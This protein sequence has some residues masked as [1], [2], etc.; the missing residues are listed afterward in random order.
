[1][2]FLSPSIRWYDEFTKR[3]NSSN[4][5]YHSVQNLL[6][7]PL[8]SR[9]IK[10]RINKTI[11][12]PVVLYGFEIWCLTLRGNIDWG[13]RLFGLVVR[14]PGCWSRGLGFD[15]LPYYIFWEIVGP[16][17]GPFS[18]ARIIEELLEWKSS[19]SVSRKPRIRPWG[20]VALTTR[21]PLSAKVGTNFADKRRSLGRCTS[22]AN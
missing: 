12:L 5:C 2:V 3:L 6:S 10:I 7:C 15:S 14:V 18:L 22:L 8:L 21:H 19:G 16:E 9:N 13:D 20:S 11:I 17:R 1:M 4:V